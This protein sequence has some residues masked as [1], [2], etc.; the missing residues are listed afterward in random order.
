MRIWHVPSNMCRTAHS[1][2][3]HWKWQWHGMCKYRL[4][5]LECIYR[6]HTKHQWGATD[7]W[8][9]FVVMS[10]KLSCHVYVAWRHNPPNLDMLRQQWVHVYIHE[11]YCESQLSK[12]GNIDRQRIPAD[13]TLQQSLHSHMMHPR[14]TRKTLTCKCY[15]DCQISWKICLL[16]YRLLSSM[17]SILKPSS[18]KWPR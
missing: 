16:P 10:E 3:R 12:F 14:I 11:T 2:V 17:T 7:T 8:A 6:N 18:K 13:I 5:I 9:I 15:N 4:Q 1:S